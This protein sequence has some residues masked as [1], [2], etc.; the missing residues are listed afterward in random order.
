MAGKMWYRMTCKGYVVLTQR[1]YSK[2]ET[3]KLFLTKDVMCEG[4]FKEDLR[5]NGLRGSSEENAEKFNGFCSDMVCDENELHDLLENMDE[6]VGNVIKYSL[7]LLKLN[8]RIH[9]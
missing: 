3:E 4:C 9:I 8:R 6:S 1:L 7:R 5:C 2:L